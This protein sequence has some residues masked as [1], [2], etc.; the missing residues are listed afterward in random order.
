MSLTCFK[1]KPKALTVTKAFVKFSGNLANCKPNTP[2]CFAA[3]PNMSLK[4]NAMPVKPSN[5]AT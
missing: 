1:L 3:S 5:A 2:V 4:L